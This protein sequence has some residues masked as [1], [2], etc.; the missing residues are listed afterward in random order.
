MRELIWAHDFGKRA[1]ISHNIER[2]KRMWYAND[3][4]SQLHNVH[5]HRAD[6]N[7]RE[8]NIRVCTI[9]LVRTLSEIAGPR[10]FA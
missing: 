2:N 6:V 8:L 3:V 10:L 7:T 5:Q 4:E 1:C 9:D